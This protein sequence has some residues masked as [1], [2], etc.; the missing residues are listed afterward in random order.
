MRGHVLFPVKRGH[1]EEGGKIL[2]PLEAAAHLP[3]RR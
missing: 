2:S 3:A 1:D